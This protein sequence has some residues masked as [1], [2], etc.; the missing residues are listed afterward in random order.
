LRT[1]PHTVP[2]NFVSHSTVE[3]GKPDSCCQ[4]NAATGIKEV[5]R[6]V[7]DELYKTPMTYRDRNKW[8]GTGL[9]LK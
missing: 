3:V 2:Q 9:A 1:L 5:G 4:S 7:L 8:I 6:G